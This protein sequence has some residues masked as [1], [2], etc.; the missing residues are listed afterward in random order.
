MTKLK[1]NYLWP[2]MKNKRFLTLYD[3]VDSLTE[4]G[5]YSEIGLGMIV[6]LKGAIREAYKA[7]F[8]DGEK[9]TQKKLQTRRSLSR[10]HRQRLSKR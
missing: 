6:K 10:V 7:G 9:A 8:K 2:M 3:W 5:G 1:L 4:C